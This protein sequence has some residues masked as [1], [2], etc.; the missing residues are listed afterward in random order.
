MHE[1]VDRMWSINIMIN[2]WNALLKVFYD[3]ITAEQSS[4]FIT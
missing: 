1:N 4:D 3:I 2:I